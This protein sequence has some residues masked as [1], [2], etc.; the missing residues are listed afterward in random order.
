MA[1]GG[2]ILSREPI[3]I[4]SQDPIQAELMVVQR[5][6][7]RSLVL[8]WY[9]WNDIVCT[10]RTEAC[11]ARLKMVGSSEWPPV[12]KVLLDTPCLPTQDDA[13]KRLTEFA[14]QIREYTKD[15]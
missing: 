5:G 8:Y 6:S 9:C 14:A 15:L 12:V 1:S 4:D 7:V 11:L 10:T 3:E 13:L 2:R